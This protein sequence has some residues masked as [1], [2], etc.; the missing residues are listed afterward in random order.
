MSLALSS[1]Q[2]VHERLTGRGD[3]VAGRV[4]AE[5]LLAHM[6]AALCTE[7]VVVLATLLRR[8]PVLHELFAGDAV[9]WAAYRK[10]SVCFPR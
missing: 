7:W 10:V 1:R 6:R 4:D 5:F 8:P 3:S 2:Q 9:L